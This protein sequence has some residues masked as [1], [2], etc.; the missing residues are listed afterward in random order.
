VIGPNVTGRAPR[1]KDQ[2]VQQQQSRA[3]IVQQR[4]KS[5]GPVRTLVGSLDQNRAAKFLRSG[6]YIQGMQTLDER[7][8][9]I[10]PCDDVE[11]AACRINNRRASNPNLRRHVAAGDVTRSKSINSFAGIDKADLPQRRGISALIIVGVKGV[12][13]VMLRGNVDNIVN[14]L[15]GYRDVG[16]IE[17]LGVSV[18]IDYVREQLSEQTWINV[19]GSKNCFPD[20]LP[21]AKI[22]I[23]PRSNHD[24]ATSRCN[25]CKQEQTRENNRFAYRQ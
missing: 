5:D 22:V 12:H 23:V 24:L 6:G 19:A 21:G 9:F 13:A 20:V 15:V 16:E 8:V 1:D 17:R 3:L 4:I 7:T 25:Q 10:G 18:A 11:R 14:A 2:S